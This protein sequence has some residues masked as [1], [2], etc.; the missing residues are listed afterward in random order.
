[1]RV[2]LGLTLLALIAVPVVTDALGQ[3]A[4]LSLATRVV[5]YAIAAA[6]LN[7]ILGYGGMISFGHAAFFGVGA[8]TVGILFSHA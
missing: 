7:F 8:Y 4:L 1:M 3:P 5:I 6:S 2:L